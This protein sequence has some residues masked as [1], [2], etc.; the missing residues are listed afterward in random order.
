MAPILNEFMDDAR[1]LVNE[2]GA[3][4]PYVNGPPVLPEET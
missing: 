1:R 3:K 2:C 4:R